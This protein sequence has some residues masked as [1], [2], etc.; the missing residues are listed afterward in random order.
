MEWKLSDWSVDD[1]SLV[2]VAKWWSKPRP[3]VGEFSNKVGVFE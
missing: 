1:Q 3:R 2:T